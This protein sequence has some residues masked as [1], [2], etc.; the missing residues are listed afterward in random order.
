MGDSVAV[1]PGVAG[2]DI[3][4]RGNT[5]RTNTAVSCTIIIA[6]AVAA[7]SCSKSVEYEPGP[8]DPYEDLKTQIA[9][10]PRPDEEA[11]LMALFA[12]GD[13]VAYQRDY[14][15]FRDAL[16]IVSTSFRDSV[17]ELDS[18]HFVYRFQVG[19]IGL[20]LK[21]AAVQQLRDG[22]FTDWDSL[23]A[24][25]RVSEIDTSGLAT[26]QQVVLTFEGRLN[27][28]LLQS[29][30]SQAVTDTSG[31]VFVRTGDYSNIYPW[32]SGYDHTFLLRKAWGNC[33]SMCDSNRFWYFKVVEGEARYL[34]EYCPDDSPYPP[35]WW[36]EAKVPFC[37]YTDH[38]LCYL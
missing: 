27:P 25:Y 24:L 11:E 1:A 26:S 20:I 30:Y 21:A 17:P 19:V 12:S 2:V 22:M 18:I 36:D 14:D 31:F 6:V 32:K 29:Y 15:R 28:L 33:M 34:G 13:V 38:P 23:N 3:V 9:Q 37:A 4:T 10:S 16:N 35:D 7:L 5:M 8:P